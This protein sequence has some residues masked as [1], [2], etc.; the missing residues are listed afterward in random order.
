M[1]ERIYQKTLTGAAA[2]DFLYNNIDFYSSY[3]EIGY[4]NV[5]I[6]LYSEKKIV[7]VIAT[8]NDLSYQD[9]MNS[10]LMFLQS[11]DKFIRDI[12][13]YSFAR[14]IAARLESR[15]KYNG[16]LLKN[17]VLYGD[18]KLLTDFSSKFLENKD[19]AKENREV[20]FNIDF[21]SDHFKYTIIENDVVVGRGVIDY[22]RFDEVISW[23]N[24][25][26]G[27]DG[28]YDSDL[29]ILKGLQKN[30]FTAIRDPAMHDL[31]NYKLLEH[32]N[33]LIDKSIVDTEKAFS[34]L[35]DKSNTVISLLDKD[36]FTNF[37]NTL[38]NIS[39]HLK[40][41]HFEKNR[42]VKELKN[43]DIKLEKH[44]RSEE[45]VFDKTKYVSLER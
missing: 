14:D 32:Y 44:L 2:I 8:K 22:C 4:K 36:K 24:E 7:F 45:R 6:N 26:A 23:L 1:N 11:Y 33:V 15:F 29:V 34:S 17:N 3:K 28:R 43:I 19:I 35:Q 40:E 18:G 25:R 16:V 39:N 20:I 10:D 21:E 38:L 41:L 42:L 31:I 30:N 5:L 9:I 27:F 13:D 37:E 12:K